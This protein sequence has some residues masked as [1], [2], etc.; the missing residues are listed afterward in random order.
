MFQNVFYSKSELLQDP[1]GHLCRVIEEEAVRAAN[2]W[3][4]AHPPSIIH[5]ERVPGL[6]GNATFQLR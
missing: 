6:P 3:L 5:E 2:D 1:S 4:K